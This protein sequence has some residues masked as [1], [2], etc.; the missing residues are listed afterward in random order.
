[1]HVLA[2]GVGFEPT[3][4][5]GSAVFKTAALDH[6][7]IPPTPGLTSVAAILNH[8]HVSSW[9]LRLR[10]VVPSRP[11]TTGRRPQAKGSETTTR[12][13]A[14]ASRRGRLPWAPR[15]GGTKRVSGEW[16]CLMRL[17]P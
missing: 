5:C 15:V 13:E 6:S 14:L 17:S 2:E 3:E 8:P 7:A 9:R 1:M 4:P 10:P 16:A 12:R 11:G